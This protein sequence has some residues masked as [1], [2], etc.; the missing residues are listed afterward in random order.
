MTKTISF[1]IGAALVAPL[2]FSSPAEAQT[3]RDIQRMEERVQEARYRGDWAAAAQLERDLNVARLAQQ[4]R[5]GI[6][7]FRDHPGFNIPGINVRVNPGVDRRHYNRGQYYP[8]P[9][10]GYYDR[11]G[12]WR[13]Y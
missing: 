11:W 1:L 4:R 8:P 12:N 7:E 5:Q 13:S 3:D 2:Y 6:G 10:S 9:N